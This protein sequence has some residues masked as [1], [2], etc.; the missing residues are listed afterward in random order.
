MFSPPLYN[1]ASCSGRLVRLTNGR[2]RSNRHTDQQCNCL[3]HTPSSTLQNIPSPFNRISKTTIVSFF[4]FYYSLS[5]IC[6]Q[7]LNNYWDK[8]EKVTNFSLTGTGRSRRPGRK[9]SWSTCPRCGTGRDGPSQS[10]PWRELSRDQ[11]IL[12][13]LWCWSRRPPYIPPR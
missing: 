6:F 10:R 11:H 1:R 4:S 8:L 9:S 13:P 5:Y 12:P 2:L 7:Q 3:P